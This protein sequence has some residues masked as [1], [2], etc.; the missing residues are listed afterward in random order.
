VNPGLQSAAYLLFRSGSR[1]GALA[2]ADV[3][4]IMRPLPIEHLT[5]AS[6][7]VMGVALVRGMPAPIIDAAQLLGESCLPREKRAFPSRFISLKLGARSACL[8]VDA[9]LDVR[10]LST[11]QLQATPPV[12]GTSASEAM[13]RIGAL[14]RELLVVLSTARMVSDAV[15]ASLPAAA[16]A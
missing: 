10:T 13:S 9:V 12:L 2:L 6:P 7:P 16:P 14:D 15:W 1:V 4:E 11:A 3:R 8:I 5:G